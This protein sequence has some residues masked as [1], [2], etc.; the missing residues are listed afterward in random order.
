M[1][2]LFTDKNGALHHGTVPRGLVRPDLWE[3]QKN[4]AHALL[5]P[6][7]AAI[8]SSSKAPFVTKVYDV[9]S[10]KASFF[11]GKVFLVGDAQTTLRPNVGMG[12]THAAN[13]CN[14][15]EKVIEGNATPEQWEIAVLRWGA[16][17]RRFAMAISAYTLGTRLDVVWAGL[18]W[19]GLLLGQ[20]VG[21][22]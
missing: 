17:Q 20:S 10:T 1:T 19:L 2:T 5:P 16:A 7:L 22:F 13:D 6:G 4:L 3:S 21:I 12:T 15:L 8:V 14:E 9:T 11:G 18:C